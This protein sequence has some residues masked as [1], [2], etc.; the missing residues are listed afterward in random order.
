MYGTWF[1]TQ[2]LEHLGQQG[3]N[4]AFVAHRINVGCAGKTAVQILAFAGAAFLRACSKA[5]VTTQRKSPKRSFKLVIR[6]QTQTAISLHTGPTI[7]RSVVGLE[8]PLRHRTGDFAPQ[9]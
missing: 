3:G 2:N 9:D 7:R 8:S 4:R 5:F 6:C 1:S